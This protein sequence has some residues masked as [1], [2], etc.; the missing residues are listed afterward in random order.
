MATATITNAGL[1]LLA[2]GLQGSQL[3]AIT[4]VA[5][6]TGAGS[7]SAGVN[8]G[9]PYTSLSVNALPAALNSG[10]SLTI[11][12]Q[13]NTDTVTLSAPAAQNATSIS[14]NSWTPAYSFPSGSVLVN[15]PSV[16]D[17]ILQA[18][19][20]RI[21][22]AAGVPGVNPGESLFTIY[23]SPTQSPGTTFCE[24]GWFGG[25]TASSAANSGTLIARGV[26]YWAHTSSDSGNIQLDT[27]V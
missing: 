6:G 23:V 20:L 7:L 24:V 1:N 21:A 4:F 5:L 18:E 22:Q 25:S 26:G 9:T 8:S 11:S 3:P 27:T 15:T 17:T 14:I 10:Q 19:V 13:N 16:N 12:Y 2:A